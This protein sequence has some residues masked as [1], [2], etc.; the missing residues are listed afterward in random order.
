[1]G[2]TTPEMGCHST[3]ESPDRVRRV[4]PPIITMRNM[5]RQAEMSQIVICLLVIESI[6][7]FFQAG[8]ISHEMIMY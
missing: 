8:K 4:T 6:D 5:S 2:G 1:M 3:I 7:V